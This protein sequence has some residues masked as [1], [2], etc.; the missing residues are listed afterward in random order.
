MYDL[1][2]G[3]GDDLVLAVQEALRELGFRDVANIDEELRLSGKG[4]RLREDLQVRDKNPVL[5]V[6]VKGVAGHPADGEVRQASTHALMRLREDRTRD[7][8][9]LS[10]VNHQRMLPPLARDNST[11]FRRELVD[12]ALQEHLGLLTTFDLFRLVRGFRRNGW[13]HDQVCRIFYGNGRIEPLPSHYEFVGTIENLWKESFSIALGAG[14]SLARDDRI[15]VEL[16]TSFAELRV[17]SLVPDQAPVESVD[18]PIEVAVRPKPGDDLRKR[19]RIFRV[20]Q[21]TDAS[22][23]PS[24]DISSMTRTAHG[25]AEPTPAG[26][27]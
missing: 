2:R 17:E 13:S 16:P 15:A 25:A 26:E 6:D 22:L 23:S 18:G 21:G 4:D 1:L 9:P 27:A 5:V 11:T 24:E 7:Y 12:A 20:R 8:K 3:T 19:M 14:T 10:I